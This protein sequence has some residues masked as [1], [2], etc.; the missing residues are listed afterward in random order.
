MH[1]EIGDQNAKRQR[2]DGDEGAA[3]VQKEDD[4]DRR[5]NQ[6]LLDQRAFQRVD[7]AVDQVGAETPAGRLAAISASRFLTLPMTVSAFSPARCSA[8]PPR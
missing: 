8:M 1:E 4:A 2:D 5:D 3:N 7:R 6:T